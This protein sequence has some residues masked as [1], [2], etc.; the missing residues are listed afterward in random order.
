MQ[1]LVVT[2]TGA[3][4]VTAILVGVKFLVFAADLSENRKTGLWRTNVVHQTDVNDDRA[5][6]LVDEV[7][8]VVEIER[9]P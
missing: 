7:V 1:H 8:D 5:F 3:G 4:V 9:C 2:D 6:D